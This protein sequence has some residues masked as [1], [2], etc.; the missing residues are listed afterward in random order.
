MLFAVDP[1]PMNRSRHSEV[2]VLGPMTSFIPPDTSLMYDSLRPTSTDT[3]LAA[4]A[5]SRTG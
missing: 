3:R 1:S 4:A 5:C 2:V